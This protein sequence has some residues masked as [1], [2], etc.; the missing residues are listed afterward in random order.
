VTPEVAVVERV[1]RAPC[2]V[3]Y[4]EWLSTESLTEWMCPRP[5]R[6]RNMELDPV[7]G[8]SYRFDIIEDGKQMI[9]VGA[10]LTLD[11]PHTIRFTWSCSTWADP[12]QQS[13]VTVQL[14]PLNETETHMTVR[15]E[16]LPPG[17]LVN[18]L[19][20]WQLIAEQL[21]KNLTDRSSTG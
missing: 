21:A 15:H 3:V 8:G 14:R 13:I 16:L 11:R 5:A 6:L 17:T 1:L 10:Y 4:D 18:H 19:E 12:T 9:V 20:G 2:D 7:V